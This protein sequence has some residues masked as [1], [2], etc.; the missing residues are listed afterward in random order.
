M[1]TTGADLL[2][3]LPAI[4]RLRD[5]E[6]AG[7]LP[8]QLSAGAQA[9][10]LALEALGGA[11][12]A[13]DSARREELRAAL[14]RGPLGA[15]LELVARQVAVLEDSVDQLYDD[16]F[17]ETAAPWVLPYLGDLIGYRLLHG[18]T[19]G[20]GSGTG[21]AR[22]RRA[23]IGHTIAL[24]RRKGTASML[25]QLARDVT[26]FPG[27]AVAELFTRLATTQ[28]M[29]H[30]R[31]HHRVAP[32]MREGAATDR[33]G[34]AF[35]AFARALDVR[36][37]E[38]GASRPNV[39]N[40]ACFVWRLDA[41]RLEGSPGVREDAKRYRFH[42]LGI[43]CQLVQRPERE[44][45]ISHLA[46]PFNVPGPITRRRL[47]DDLPRLY[48]PESSLA[49]WLDDALVP[50]ADVV[51]ANLA[52]APGGWMR[53]PAAGKVLV[54]PVLGRL[55]VS[56]TPTRV[57]VMFHRAGVNGAFGG[58]YPRAH[59]FGGLAGAVVRVPQDHPT[60]QAGLDALAGSGT[61]EITDSGT[62]AESLTITVLPGAMIQLRAADG[63]RPTLALTGE[64]TVQG[65]SGSEV[66]LNGLQ[67]TNRPVVVPAGSQLDRLAVRHCTLVPGAR[68]QP[69][70]SPVTAGALGVDV[71]RDRTE[72]T[73]EHS[74]VGA[75][76]GAARTRMT[77]IHS[78]VDATDA[79]LEA[80]GAGGSAVGALTLESATVIGRI[81]AQ[82]LSMSDSIAL[83]LVEVVNRQ[84]GCARFSYLPLGSLAPRRHRC[85]P[86]QPVDVPHF[87]SLRFSAPA[88]A[89]LATRTPEA[90]RRGA[91]DESEMG[92][93]HRL[94]EPQRIADL[95][96]RLDEYLRLGLRAGVV[97]ES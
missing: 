75:L 71:R 10:L 58:E 95:I 41:L 38:Q 96:T 23:E 84:A 18:S 54:D 66:E 31:R 89:R 73:V 36:A 63:R 12:D 14:A 74:V 16:L 30:V 80:I 22:G 59:T 25:E 90:I 81:R 33:V 50:V 42:P 94:Q 56:G 52:D 70:G 93:H 65:G 83:G 79:G 48:G 24:R 68:L 43:D 9:E 44:E 28:S 60:V 1:T 46:E 26:G 61:V 5:E 64:L 97:H 2:A 76:K 86:Q 7:R 20:V 85:A 34:S 6:L 40:I 37:I 88:Y 32:S 92:A 19:P 82:Q 13:Q 69:D 55:A 87:A 72:L 3:L 29:N 45:E 57:E 17:V 27:A 91:E 35:D 39:G 4:Y 62:Y 15:L 77:V 47:L 8:A 49:I 21:S 67:L 11:A 78:I 53:T 51:A